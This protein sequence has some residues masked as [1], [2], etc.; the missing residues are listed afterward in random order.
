MRFPPEKGAFHPEKQG[1]NAPFWRV[2]SRPSG[3]QDRRRP[4]RDRPKRTLMPRFG[5]PTGW[6]CH[7][8]TFHIDQM[9]PLMSQSTEPADLPADSPAIWP[10]FA[11]TCVK[12]TLVCFVLLATCSWGLLVTP[13]P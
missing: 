7:R 4:A 2:G 13:A 1:G 9:L 10:S 11:I 5:R 6:I 12:R 3:L 8:G